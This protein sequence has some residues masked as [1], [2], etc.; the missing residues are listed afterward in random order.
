MRASWHR[1]PASREALYTGELARF[2]RLLAELGHRNIAVVLY[3]GPTHPAHDSLVAEAGLA[4][5]H[6]RW[7]ADVARIA[8]DQGAV[9]VPADRPGFLATVRGLPAGCDVVGATIV[10]E[11]RR[12]SPPLPDHR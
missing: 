4:T 8:A 1:G 7:R 2:T 6:A 5:F 11:G 3:V 9:L 12:L 10:R